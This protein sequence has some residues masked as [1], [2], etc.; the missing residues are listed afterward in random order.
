MNELARNT[1]LNNKNQRNKNFEEKRVKFLNPIVINNKNNKKEIRKRR[2][3]RER[4]DWKETHGINF[5]WKRK[6]TKRTNKRYNVVALRE[7]ENRIITH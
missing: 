4:I 5:S 6:V 2:R 7:Y 1:F 3:K